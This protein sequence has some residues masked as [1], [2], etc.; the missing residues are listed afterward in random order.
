MTTLKLRPLAAFGLIVSITACASVATHPPAPRAA[1][2]TVIHDDIAYLASDRLEGRLT[3]SV[4]NDSAAAYIARRYAKLRLRP[5]S[6]GY[7]QKFMARSAAD[8]HAGTTQGRP[9][10]NVIAILPGSDPHLAGQYIVVGAHF[11]HLGRDGQFALDPE[12]KDAIRNGADDNASGTA[13][14]LQL[15]RILAP[16]HPRRSIIFANFSGEE[17]GLLGSQ[18]F[19]EHPPVPLDSIIAM[20]NFDM[21]GRLNSDKL[22]IYGTATATEFAA[23]L[24]SAN[25]KSAV[26]FKVSGGGDGFGSS[27]QSSFYAKN[28]PVLHFFTDLHSDY[29][30]ATDDADKINSSGEARVVD[31]ATRVIQSLDKLPARL[32]FVRLTTPSRM[33]VSASSG[34]QVYLGS[35]PDMA[36]GDIPGL[37]LT[38]VRPGSPAEL[39]GLKADDIIIEF[40]GAKVTD[41]QSYSD[42]LYAHKPGEAV[43]VIVLR[44]GKP[45]ELTVTLGKRGG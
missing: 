45:V 29:H 20:V 16:T 6:S 14:V 31:L 26:P 8:A 34:N 38:G 27:D 19:V 22:I 15:A 21:V 43:K 36:A 32:S 40:G 10:Q 7:L 4:G 35:V 44:A 11:D 37:K 28:I 18:W 24:D 12:A 33:A 2:S 17:E 41:L 13:A 25:A 23:I 3:G 9:T 1:D 30:R 5:G 42:A 39:G